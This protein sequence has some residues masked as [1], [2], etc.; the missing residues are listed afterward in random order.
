MTG[1]CSL[2]PNTKTNHEDCKIPRLYTMNEIISKNYVDLQENICGLYLQLFN[3]NLDWFK[4]MHP[5]EENSIIDYT[6]I[7]QK[8]RKCHVEL[9]QRLATIDEYDTIL[10]DPTKLWAWT[11]I[12]TTGATNNEQRLYFNFMSDG[13]IIFDL[14]NQSEMAFYPNKK[15][16]NPALGKY[17]YRDKIGLPTK[18]AIIFK[19]NKDGTMTR[20]HNERY[21]K[22][23]NKSQET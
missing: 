8:N 17:E 22:T 19:Y 7:D 14:N 9:K 16:W 10:L 23:Y 4:V 6:C 21:N 13:V 5:N 15:I 2:T 3:N 1:K 18:N 12:G 20:V 11:K